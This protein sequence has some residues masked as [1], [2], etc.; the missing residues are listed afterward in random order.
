MLPDTFWEC[1]LAEALLF[2]RGQEDRER[3]EWNRQAHFMSLTYNLNRGRNRALSWEDFT[4]YG[5]PMKHAEATVVT[6][7]FKQDLL[8]MQRLMN[9]G[10]R[11]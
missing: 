6:D 9:N 3:S 7:D 1:T 4:P 11:H 5:I 8:T 2:L 10:T